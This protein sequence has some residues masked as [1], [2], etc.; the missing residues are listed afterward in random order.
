MNPLK[1]VLVAALE[2]IVGVIPERWQQ[3]VS[4]VTTMIDRADWGAT[5][6]RWADVAK[7]VAEL[8]TDLKQAGATSGTDL[9]LAA[10]RV[11]EVKYTK[12][13]AALGLLEVV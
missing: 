10:R 2:V 4:V 7:I 3:I 8:L 9:A 11:A 5:D 13:L 12:Q 1:D 6:S